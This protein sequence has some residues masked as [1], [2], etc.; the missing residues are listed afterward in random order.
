MD[1]KTN[2]FGRQ[3]VDMFCARSCQFGYQSVSGIQ[4]AEK[5]IELNRLFPVI[6][7]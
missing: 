6:N 3:N 5:I 4:V 2:R 7:Y 1:P